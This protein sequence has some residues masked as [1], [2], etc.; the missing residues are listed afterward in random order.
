MKNN[1]PIYPFLGL[2]ATLLI[3]LSCGKS[4]TPVDPA[5]PNLPLRSPHPDTVSKPSKP[6][7]T[8]TPPPAPPYPQVP[9]NGCYFAPVY[10]DSIIYPQPTNGQDYIVG[11]V[12]SPGAGKY[13]SWPAGMVIDYT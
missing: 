10:G 1:L 9:L 6:D 11:P 2:I 12:N 4:V 7:T 3:V 13:L 5:S 8:T